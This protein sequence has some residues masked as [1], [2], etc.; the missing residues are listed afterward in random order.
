MALRARS[1]VSRKIRRGRARSRGTR[2][3]RPEDEGI[4]LRAGAGLHVFLRG[5]AIQSRAARDFLVGAVLAVEERA[6]ALEHFLGCQRAGSRV[7]HEFVGGIVD[8]RWQVSGV[9]AGEEDPA[10][11]LLELAHVAGPGI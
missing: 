9:A 6:V 8:R 10:N 7:P 5:P 1:T 3:S 4:R 11:R 2:R